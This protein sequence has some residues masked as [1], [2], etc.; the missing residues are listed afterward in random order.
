M[1]VIIAS[2]FYWILYGIAKACTDSLR[3][4]P[5]KN[6]L[7][8]LLM[9]SKDPFWIKFACETVP[10]KISYFRGIWH[11][12][13]WIKEFCILSIAFVNLC[14]RPENISV[15]PIV[16][17]FHIISFWIAGQVFL[18]FYDKLLKL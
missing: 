14:Y 17:G 4:Y 8:N 10:T 18:L 12:C 13:E 15:L 7:R 2:S 3:D 11:Y 16:A 6:R 1:A 9:F 5:Y